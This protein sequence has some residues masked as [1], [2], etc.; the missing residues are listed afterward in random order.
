MVRTRFTMTLREDKN[1]EIKRTKK[2]GKMNNKGA[3]VC[4]SKSKYRE[5][6]RRERQRERERD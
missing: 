4:L 1:K 5:R 6:E 3:Q 2:R